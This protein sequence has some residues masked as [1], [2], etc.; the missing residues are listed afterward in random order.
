MTRQIRVLAI[1]GSLRKQSFNGLALREAIALAPPGM[2][3]DVYG[4]LGDIPPFNQDH[5]D[6]GLAPVAALKHA[7]RKA[8]A[9]LLCTPEYN[10]SIPGVL[11]NALDWASFPASTDNALAGKPVAILG[12]SQSPIGTARAQEQLRQ[13]L[14]FVDM[15]VVNKP[16]VLIGLAGT[17][18]DGG[19]RLVDEVALR[20]IAQLLANLKTLADKQVHAA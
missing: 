6:A 13:V 16:E 10:H 17:R 14:A 7:I 19:G 8:D 5:A 18:F 12:V 20:L 9:I 4:G 1:N 15:Q 3:I 11:K 2:A